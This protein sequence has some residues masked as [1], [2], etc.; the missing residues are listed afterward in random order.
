MNGP[1]LRRLAVDARHLVPGQPGAGVAHA[2]RELIAVLRERAGDFGIEIVTYTGR[3]SGRSIARQGRRHNIGA[4]L[5]PSGVVSPFLRGTIYPW[6]HD[7]AIFEHPEWFPQSI[8]KRL[9]TTNVFING[10]KR[11][12]HIFAVSDDTKQAILKRTR[13]SPED[14]TVTYQ[15]ISPHASTGRNNTAEYALILGT[16]E[17]RKNIHFIV[18]LWP[19]VLRRTGRNIQLVIAGSSGW[20]GVDEQLKTNGA[21]PP[22]VRRVSS[23]DDVERDSLIEN[24]SVFLLPSLHEG[25]GRTGVEALSA[26]VAVV[27]S[28]AGALPEILGPAARFVDPKD[29]QGWTDAIA[30]SLNAKVDP[31]ILRA[32]AA[33]FT[34]TSTADIMLAKIAETWYVL[35]HK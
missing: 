9:V 5:V 20:G 18:D 17:P 15:G 21:Y 29:R 26:G 14:I 23:F 34:W 32:H 1:R 35:G 33:R 27:A 28:R 12:R 31:D 22:Y 25:F 2:S 30:D 11:A 4:W 19:D 3:Q 24:A 8:L 6:V 16:V 13:R 10:L 7:L